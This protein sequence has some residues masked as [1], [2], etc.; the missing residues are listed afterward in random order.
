MQV[1]MRQQVPVEL[2]RPTC[3]GIG[4]DRRHD[5]AQRRR[6]LPQPGAIENPIP[7]RTE[8]VASASSDAKRLSSPAR[9]AATA[10]DR[11]SRPG[12]TIVRHNLCSQVHAS[13][14]SPSRAPPAGRSRSCPSSGWPPP[15]GAEPGRQW[16]RVSWRIVP[17]VTDVCG[18]QAAHSKR[19]PRPRRPRT[20]DTGSRRAIAAAPGRPDTLTG[21]WRRSRNK[22]PPGRVRLSSESRG[23]SALPLFSSGAAP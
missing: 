2:T 1:G 21:S 18:P 16:H 13:R 3:E 6:A 19:A 14:S 11:G 4:Q 9:H 12:R 17:A 23:A 22:L 8:G 5:L 15:H 10:P 7:G 20:S